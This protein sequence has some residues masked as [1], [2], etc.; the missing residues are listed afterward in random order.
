M[1]TESNISIC[2]DPRM[3][4]KFDIPQHI[5]INID[6]QYGQVAT[7]KNTIYELV[8]NR[9]DLLYT[10]DNKWVLFIDADTEADSFCSQFNFSLRARGNFTESF[11]DQSKRGTFVWKLAPGVSLDGKTLGLLEADVRNNSSLILSKNGH[12]G[13]FA[14][15]DWENKTVYFEYKEYSKTTTSISAKYGCGIKEI[16]WIPNFTK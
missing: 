13:W 11:P 15:E 9:Q 16:P 1:T 6:K 12:T 3:C 7:S 2:K 10:L 14:S 5:N 4:K 8:R